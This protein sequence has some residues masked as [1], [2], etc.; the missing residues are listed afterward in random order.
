MFG[1]RFDGYSPTMASHW[2]ILAVVPAVVGAPEP[3][4]RQV[5]GGIVRMVVGRLVGPDRVS[6][7]T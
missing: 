3:L 4:R 5:P 6:V 1:H 2:G 7:F